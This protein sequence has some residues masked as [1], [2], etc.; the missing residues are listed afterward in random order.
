MRRMYIFKTSKYEYDDM[1]ASLHNQLKGNQDYIENRIVLNDSETRR[2]G[3]TC[4][5]HV[6]IFEDC[7]NIPE[8]KI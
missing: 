1:L 4:E 5:I 2:D 3:T 8:L 6:Y 7:E